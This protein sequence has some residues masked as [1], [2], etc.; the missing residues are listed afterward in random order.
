[1]LGQG[2][3]TSPQRDRKLGEARLQAS[4]ITSAVYKQGE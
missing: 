3:L 1:M 2:G 4:P